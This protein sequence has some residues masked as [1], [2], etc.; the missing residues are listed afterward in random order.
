MPCK[1][2]CRPCK[3]KSKFLFNGGLCPWTLKSSLLQVA[4][5]NRQS[6]YNRKRSSSAVSCYS[7]TLGT[8]SNSY[9]CLSSKLWGNF[10][11]FILSKASST[12]EYFAILVNNFQYLIFKSVLTSAGEDCALQLILVHTSRDSLCSSRHRSSKKLPSAT[13]ATFRKSK[14]LKFGLI[15]WKI[16]CQICCYLHQQEIKCE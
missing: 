6:I 8:Y 5:L 16:I 10:F 3:G 7:L 12:W 13:N 15:V 14:K 11:A 9:A 1:T 4:R 2:H